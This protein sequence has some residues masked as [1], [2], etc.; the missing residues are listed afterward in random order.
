VWACK[1]YDG[2]SHSLH[3]CHVPCILALKWD[4]S[5]FSSLHEERFHLLRTVVVCH[6]TQ[7]QLKSFVGICVLATGSEGLNAIDA[8]HG[9]MAIYQYISHSLQWQYTVEGSVW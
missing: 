8:S 5:K 7:F 2:A 4:V 1:N 3:T 9:Y 6:S